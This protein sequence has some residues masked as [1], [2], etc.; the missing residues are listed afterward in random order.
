V[1]QDRQNAPAAGSQ[2]STPTATG[3]DTSLPPWRD[4]QA[5]GGSGSRPALTCP[6]EIEPY[7]FV[8]IALLCHMANAL[9]ISPGNRL[10]DL[11]CGRGGPGL[12]PAQSQGTA[13]IGVDFSTVAVRQATARA[14]GWC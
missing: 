8:S 4:R 5:S 3:F 7:S 13:L 1:S 6:A 11:G 14:V 10:V 2:P 12:W 9:G